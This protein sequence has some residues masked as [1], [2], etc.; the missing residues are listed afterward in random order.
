MRGRFTVE[1]SAREFALLQFHQMRNGEGLGDTLLRLAG[2][3]QDTKEGAGADL[4]DDRARLA[5]A[6]R[7][8]VSELLSEAK[9]SSTPTTEPRPDTIELIDID[10]TKR[11]WTA[12]AESLARR[13]HEVY[14]RLAPSFDYRTRPASAV[15][16]EDV[17][18]ANQRLMI[19]TCAEI[20]KAADLDV[21]SG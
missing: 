10:D 21:S 2:L 6:A 7:P 4:G 19:A 5:V 18:E 12:T 15:P 17:P 1:I 11:F 20:L 16:W 9:Q 13:F 8:I 14:E 3:R